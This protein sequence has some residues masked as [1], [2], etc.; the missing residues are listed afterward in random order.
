VAFFVLIGRDRLA[1]GPLRQSLRPAH[2]AHFF[3][4]RP[5]CRGVAGGPLLDDA[6]EQMVGSLL[7]FEAVDRAAV[8]RFVADDPY[9]RAGLFE[10]VEIIPWRWGLGRPD[11]VFAARPE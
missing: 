8:D 4:P 6:G 2:Q 10:T 3:A 1:T 9:T 7:V 11:A 5:D